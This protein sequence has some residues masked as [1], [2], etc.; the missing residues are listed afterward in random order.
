MNQKGFIDFTPLFWFGIIVGIIA[1]AIGY[2]VIQFLIWIVS[3]L[4]WT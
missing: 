4:Q 1:S 2:G 3:H